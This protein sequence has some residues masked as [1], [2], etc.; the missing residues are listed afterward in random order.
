MYAVQVTVLYNSKMYTQGSI[1]PRPNIFT[2]GYLCFTVQ[3]LYHNHISW[4]ISA[5]TLNPNSFDIR[6][7]L[8]M[9]RFRKLI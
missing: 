9:E 6:N 1:K 5:F 8:E 7:K 2:C 4:E 3:W